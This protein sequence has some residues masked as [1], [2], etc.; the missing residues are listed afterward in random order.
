M[1]ATVVLENAA[2]LAA[3]ADAYKSDG[4][5][6]KADDAYALFA[7]T[8]LTAPSAVH[9]YTETV[10]DYDDEPDY[11]DVAHAVIGTAG[12]CIPVPMLTAAATL[13]ARARLDVRCVHAR[14]WIE[15]SHA[16]KVRLF[17]EWR[18][19]LDAIGQAFLFDARRWALEVR[20]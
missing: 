4:D 18:E 2:R 11:Y 13:Q 6:T 3:I 8:A 19:I 20:P 16:E 17:V 7:W 10:G 12:V 1:S 14:Q 5:P 15:L 9:L